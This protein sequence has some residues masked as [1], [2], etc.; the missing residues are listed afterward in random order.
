MRL[1]LFR[2]SVYFSMP[3]ELQAS[4][5]VF[6]IDEHFAATN[7]RPFDFNDEHIDD[8]LQH[9]FDCALVRSHFFERPTVSSRSIRLLLRKTY[10]KNMP[11][12]RRAR[13]NPTANSS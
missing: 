8:D 7:Y 6:D 11:T 5:F 13:L 1:T 3:E 2:P 4:S 9:T 10:G 12:P